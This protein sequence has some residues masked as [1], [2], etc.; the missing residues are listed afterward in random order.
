MPREFL[1][2]GFD[3]K[4]VESYYKF[5]VENAKMFNADEK[6]AEQELKESLE[7]EIKLAN[8]MYNF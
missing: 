6:K 5:M 7:F 8:V 1:V 3:D 4:I 2:K